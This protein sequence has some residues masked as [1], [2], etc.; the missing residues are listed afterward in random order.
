MNFPLVRKVSIACVLL[1]S[2]CGG[3]EFGDVSVDITT[4]SLPPAV[5]LQGDGRLGELTRWTKD[6]YGVPAMGVVVVIDGQVVDQAAE[7]LRSADDIVA[8]TV[9][10]RWH[11]G[12]LTK[13]MTA[14][15]AA[16]LVEQSV[17]SWET[18][19]LDVWPELD[20]SIHPSL[21]SITLRQLLSHTAGIRRVNA[22]PS[23][24]GDAAAGTRVEKRRAFAA[25][26][27]AETPSSPVG[28]ESYSNGGYIIAGAMMETLM[29][30][31]WEN[32]MS[33]Y[34]FAPLSMNETGFGAPGTAALLNEPYGHW[35]SGNRYDPVPPGPDA[36]NPQVFGPAGTVHST[37]ADYAK[38]IAAHVDGANGVDGFITAAS[39]DTLHT[40]V[41]NGSALGWG[42]IDSEE[43]P[44][45]TELAHSGSNGRWFAVVRILP[46][47]D[48]GALLVVNAGG[49]AAEDAIDELA[50]ILAERYRNAQ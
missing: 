13:S 14:T 5:G 16:A 48:G 19:P 27:L 40:P 46:E 21:R 49:S 23:Q 18:T 45:R 7:G 12:S 4:P 34:V 10:D 31:S 41:D 42:V 25:E 15:L 26:L 33:D 32:L 2:A 29:T 35:D 50:G 28:T 22:A 17:L 8:V 11:L 43:F 3:N 24:Y 37:F 6:T 30:A 9:T 1:L 36:D 20:Q 44:G 47:L 38:Y 39:F